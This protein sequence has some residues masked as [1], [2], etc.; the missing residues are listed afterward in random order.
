MCRTFSWKDGYF[1]VVLRMAGSCNAIH[2]DISICRLADKMDWLGEKSGRVSE[3]RLQFSALATC[4]DFRSVEVISDVQCP[5]FDSP[6]SSIWC[7]SVLPVFVWGHQRQSLAFYNNSTGCTHS[8]VSHANKAT[9][10]MFDSSWFC[11]SALETHHT[12][13][14]PEDCY[15]FG[16]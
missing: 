14:L 3:P 8:Q 12:I 13:E 2:V 9:D 1:F 16:W 6:S 10:C 11:W 7:A 5:D 4:L 15:E